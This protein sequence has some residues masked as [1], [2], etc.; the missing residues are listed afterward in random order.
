[1]QIDWTTFVLE[2]VNFLVL[3]WILKRFLYKPVLAILTR[4]RAATERTLAEANEAEQRAAGL[5][6]QYENRLADW[7]TERGTARTRLEAEMAAERMRQMQAL[8]KDLAEERERNVVLENHRRNESRRE[9]ETQALAQA[10]RFAA[11][12]LSRLAGP[13]LETR[14]AGV[15]IEEV[16]GL[17]EDQIAGLHAAAWNQETRVAVTSAF[18]LSVVQRKQIEEVLADRAGRSLPVDFGVDDTL[19]AGL[20]V[21]IGPWQLNMNLADELAYFSRA[22]SHAD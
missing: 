20:R 2:I 22:S 19:L 8:A 6:V 4:R 1:M 17:A 10:S 13:E 21:S 5:K 12:L 9:M 11:G 7:E 16:A 3:V 18:P 14:L 15:F